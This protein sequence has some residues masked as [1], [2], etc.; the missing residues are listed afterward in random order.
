MNKK[1]INS[2]YIYEQFEDKQKEI[3]RKIDKADKLAQLIQQNYANNMNNIS[4]K[5]KE[6]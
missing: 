6:R 1:I 5:Y 4:Q 2:D 3:N